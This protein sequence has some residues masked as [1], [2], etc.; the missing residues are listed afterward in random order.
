MTLL[1]AIM[2]QMQLATTGLAFL[3]LTARASAVATSSSMRAATALTVA[4]SKV[5]SN[6]HSLVTSKHGRCLTVL[7]KSKSKLSVP[8][9]ETVR[10]TQPLVDAERRCVQRLLLP[11]V[12]HST[13]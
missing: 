12:L 4:D 11:Q 9:A 13:S 1:H 5:N 7:L 6:F 10:V 3:S 2:T 8:K